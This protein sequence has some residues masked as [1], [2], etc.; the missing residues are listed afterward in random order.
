MK[1]I[2]V[3][4]LLVLTLVMSSV[5]CVNAAG[6][7]TLD[8][9]WATYSA[10]EVKVPVDI[11]AKIAGGTYADSVSDYSGKEVVV[12]AILDMS[13]VKKVVRRVEEE[14]TAADWN[15]VKDMAVSGSFDISVTWSGV[16]AP[17]DI[18]NGSLAGFS[19]DGVTTTGIFEEGATRLVSGNILSTTIVVKDGVKVSDLSGLPS[20]IVL[21]QD[22]FTLVSSGS[23]SGSITG[24]TTIGSTYSIPYSFLTIE[25]VLISKRAIGGS[26]ITPD[27]SDKD[28]DNDNKEPDVD[29]NKPVATQKNFSDVH[30]VNHWGAEA[31]SFMCEKGFMLGVTDELF[32]PDDD[33]TRG[34]FIT[35][36]YRM[37]NEPE[38][39][40]E[41]AFKDIEKGFYYEAAIAWGTENGII[42]GYDEETY[43][44][45]DSITREQMAAI[46]QRYA[47]FK[48]LDTTASE[49][50]SYKD[51]DDISEY[52]KTAVAWNTEAGTLQGNEDGTFAPQSNA[53][54]AE[55]A[56]VFMRV[57]NLFN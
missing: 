39:S 47:A 7:L 36:L 40:F 51:S 18:T 5:C 11:Q 50:A 21:E 31:I 52:A 48:G 43:A 10:R 55:A 8:Q 22:G 30:D 27:D 46:I 23:I 1:R 25:P 45:D 44:P 33:I 34:M 24:F 54:R 35:V 17:A 56:A 9:L 53:T 37:E 16:N 26:A 13:D 38:T 32:A 41:A 3:A 4:M 12:K 19:F 29:D 49:E 6:A 42:L 20:E 28:N 15:T 2:F 57:F 14:L